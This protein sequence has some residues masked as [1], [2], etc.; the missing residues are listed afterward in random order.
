MQPR[1]LRRCRCSGPPA[2]RFDD[3]S[4]GKPDV[5]QG[6]AT[7]SRPQPAAD[8]EPASTPGGFQSCGGPRGGPGT[9]YLNGPQGRGTL[10]VDN[11]GQASQGAA[12]VAGAYEFDAIRLTQAGHLR[13]L[14]AGSVLTLTNS[15]LSGDSTG[16]RLIGEG[17]IV[18]PA[19]LTIE[20]PT[21]VVQGELSGP[22][23]ITTQGSGGLE[24]AA[25]TPWHSGAYTFTAITVGAGT[26]LSL[27][28][29]DDGDADYGDDYGVTLALDQLTV[30]AGGTVS[31]DGLGYGSGR[32]PGA[33]QT[34]GCAGGGGSYG[35]PGSGDSGARAGPTYGSLSAPVH[36]GSGGGG[37][38]FGPGAAGGGALRLR[39]PAR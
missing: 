21:L 38:G 33:G 35:G 11:N 17:R 26:R 36:L 23:S 7:R 4:E 12:L 10:L 2:S 34:T 25:H 3:E 28:G 32:G 19:S 1:S 9:I 29:Y 14:G 24:L 15:S 16:A 31:A 39:V 13:V 22:Q 8:R 20:G 27:A 18:A 37:G 6:R 30:A 5:T